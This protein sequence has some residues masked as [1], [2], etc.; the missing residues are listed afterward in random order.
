ME[1]KEFGTNVMDEVECIYEECGWSAYLGDKEKLER[2][3]E[4]SYYRLG[5]FDDGVLVG[6]V[7][8][9]G[10]GEHILYVQDL[11]VKPSHQR[12]GIGSRLMKFVSERFSEVRQF[13]LIT[14]AEDEIS[15]S[16]YQ[17][18]GM[19][20]KINGSHSARHYFRGKL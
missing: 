13:L 19:E 15:N 12:R 14:D 2:A 7:R 5:A 18:I 4:N 10:D 6:F 17:A 9:V 8:C 3:F 11:I 20:E 1:Y 16:F